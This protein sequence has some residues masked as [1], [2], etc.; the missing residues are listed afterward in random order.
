[1]GKRLPA[2]PHLDHLRRQAKDLLAA[3]RDGD[4][5]AAGTFREHL[6]AARAMTDDQVRRA[7]YR[8]ADAQAAV[9]RQTGF[10]GWPHLARHV[11]ALRGWRGRGRSPT[12]RSTARSCPWG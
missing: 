7:G 5:V 3:L 10:A 4:P 12:W 9:A 6:P 1:M 2:R 8:L 11:E